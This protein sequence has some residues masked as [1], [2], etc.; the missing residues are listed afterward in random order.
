VTQVDVDEVFV[1]DPART[2][3]PF[4]ELGSGESQARPFGQRVEQ[5]EFGAGQLHRYPGEV[6]L[7]GLRVDRQRPEPALG[8]L[9][10]R[11][12]G[13]ARSAQHHLDP[14]HQ[15]A[16]RERFG[17]VV[18]GTY[19]QADQLVHLLGAGGEHDDVRIGERP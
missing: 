5:I 18:V 7:P 10:R 14:G 1:T 13:A 17:Q 8:C 15:L 11:R 6:D 19:R 3:D 12:G 16:G 4:D 9:R 2:P